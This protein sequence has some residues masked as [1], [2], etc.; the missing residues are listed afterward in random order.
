MRLRYDCAS[1]F[2]RR[3]KFWLFPNKRNEEFEMNSRVGSSSVM[4]R[5]RS[6]IGGNLIKE[7]PI[8]ERLV[9]MELPHISRHFIHL[10]RSIGHGAFGEVFEGFFH[11][12][13]SV[14][15][16]A[17][18]TLPIDSNPESDVDFETEARLLK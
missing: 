1:P 13:D 17:V 6:T 18:K 12:N 15:R 5:S 3:I 2:M 14:T 10:N 11:L 9:M 16:V 8:Y 7:N 4:E